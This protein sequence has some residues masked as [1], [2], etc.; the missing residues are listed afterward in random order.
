MTVTTGDTIDVDVVGRTAWTS[1]TM[2]NSWVAY[3]APFGGAE[4]RKVGDM[5]Q[6][7]GVIKSGSTTATMFTLPAGYR[8]PY[9]VQFACAAGGG[10]YGSFAV[11]PD[12]TVVHQVGSNASMA[13]QCM[14]SVTS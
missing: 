6:I 3:G 2:Q 8:P 11:D 9:R 1:P 14:F 12:G 7:R 13:L 4:Y 5:V 10:A